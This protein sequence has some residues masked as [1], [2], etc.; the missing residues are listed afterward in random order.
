MCLLLP[1]PSAVYVMSVVSKCR[2]DKKS[3]TAPTVSHSK[4]A[5]IPL[6]GPRAA[7]D[8][9]WREKRLTVAVAVAGRCKN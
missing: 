9:A 7:P 8:K 4:S 5:N 3:A 1:S 6:R 2:V